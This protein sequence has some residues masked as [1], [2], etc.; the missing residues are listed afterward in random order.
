MRGLYIIVAGILCV[1]IASCSISIKKTNK[2]SKDQATISSITGHKW[3]L[4]N[5]NGKNAGMDK[6]MKKT[7]HVQFGADSV[8]SGNGGCNGYGG[9]YV[10]KGTNGI[11]ISDVMSTLIACANNNVQ[12]QEVALFKL[13][14]EADH[15]TIKNNTLTIYSKD[16]QSFA[17]F[18]TEE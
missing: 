17:K 12:K 13:Y 2:N 9:K 8:I 15:Y 3:V 11:E 18:R 14:R 6:Q 5:L 4:T 1:T 16:E 10:L 7:P